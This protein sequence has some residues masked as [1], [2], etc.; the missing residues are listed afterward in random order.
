[1]R[2]HSITSAVV[3]ADLCLR[4]LPLRL[5]TLHSVEE[6]EAA[7]RGQ[8][9]PHWWLLS[10]SGKLAAESFEAYMKAASQSHALG[11]GVICGYGD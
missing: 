4:G 7:W 3:Y 2:Q 9:W 6:A 1:M 10:R 5:Q 11:E 8:E